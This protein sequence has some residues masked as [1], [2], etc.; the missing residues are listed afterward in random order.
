MGRWPMADADGFRRRWPMA[1]GPMA[2]SPMPMAD[3]DGLKSLLNNLNK[4]QAACSRITHAVNREIGT[5]LDL[6]LSPRVFL[7]FSSKF[8]SWQV[9]TLVGGTRHACGRGLVP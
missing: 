9:G 5:N 4:A 2:L 1:D 7:N 3:A 6:A 8:L